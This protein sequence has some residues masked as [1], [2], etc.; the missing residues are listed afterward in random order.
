M[1]EGGGEEVDLGLQDAE[2]ETYGSRMKRQM[3]ERLAARKRRAGRGGDSPVRPLQPPAPPPPPTSLLTTGLDGVIP[4][5][6]LQPP[7]PPPPPPPPTS[8]LTVGS[9]GKAEIRRR[10]IAKSVE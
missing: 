6:P 10:Q 2:Q 1:A 3:A 4:A 9:A 8:L 5:R 7:P